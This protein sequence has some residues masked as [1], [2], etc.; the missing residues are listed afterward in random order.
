ML[1]T[2]D[3]RG[4]VGGSRGEGRSKGKGGGGETEFGCGD[5]TLNTLCI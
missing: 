5:D 2:G 4:E 1:L 3:A